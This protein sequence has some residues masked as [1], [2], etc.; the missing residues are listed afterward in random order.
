M[1]VL[2][3]FSEKSL[4]DSNVA[5]LALAP[6]TSPISDELRALI[7]LVEDACPC[8][9]QVS[10]SFGHELKISIDVRTLEEVHMVETT[11]PRL[12]GGLFDNISRSAIPHHA[13][14]KRVSATV[15]K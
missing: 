9:M 1:T 13:F 2:T 15:H 14:L 5:E 11:L 7:H 3:N 8:P 4:S 10:F 6:R 12:A